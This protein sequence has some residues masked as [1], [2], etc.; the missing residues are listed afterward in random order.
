MDDSGVW[1]SGIAAVIFWTIALFFL[2]KYAVRE[3]INA[4]V[5]GKGSHAPPKADHPWVGPASPPSVEDA[6]RRIP[7]TKPARPK[8]TQQELDA[9]IS[10]NLRR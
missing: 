7:A 8:P 6:S 3:G 4:S 1:G 10:R 9:E 2:I 5:L